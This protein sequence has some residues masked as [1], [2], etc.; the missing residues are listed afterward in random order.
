MVPGSGGGAGRSVSTVPSVFDDVAVSSDRLETIQQTKSGSAPLK[1]GKRQTALSSFFGTSVTIR[2]LPLTIIC[3]WEKRAP[4]PHEKE[5]PGSK[6]LSQYIKNTPLS[7][8][9]GKVSENFH[10]GIKLSGFL[11]S[12]L[13]MTIVRPYWL[14]R[15]RDRIRVFGKHKMHRLHKM[16][17]KQA[18][19]RPRASLILIPRR[20]GRMEE[21]VSTVPASEG[22]ALRI[23]IQK[24]RPRKSIRC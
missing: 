15:R 9:S 2:P 8:F 14:S 10:T 13:T 16:M 18:E 1:R 22:R 23:S 12:Q 24:D 21:R 7:T 17:S 11:H 5:V 19:R 3:E 4:Y 6:D 20:Y